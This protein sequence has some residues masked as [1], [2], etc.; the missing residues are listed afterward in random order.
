MTKPAIC[1]SWAGCQTRMPDICKPNGKEGIY[2][3]EVTEIQ[4]RPEKVPSIISFWTF[5][6]FLGIVTTTFTMRSPRLSEPRNGIPCPLSRK[7]VWLCVPG[8]T[9]RT[10]FPVR[11]CT[12]ISPPR[13]AV[14]SPMFVLLWRSVPCRSNDGCALTWTTA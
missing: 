14:R 3:P 6:R 12:V 11:V 7:R 9:V 10:A 8:G 4:V 1:S 2:F 5:V 13:R